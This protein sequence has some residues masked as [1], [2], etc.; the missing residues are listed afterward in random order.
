MFAYTLLDIFIHLTS[1]V[2]REFK[3]ASS[4][5]RQGGRRQDVGGGGEVGAYVGLLG[6]AGVGVFGQG[7]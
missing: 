3:T 7:G 6:G 4:G 1:L 2:R 5:G